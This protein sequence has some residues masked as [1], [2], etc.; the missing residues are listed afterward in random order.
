[1]VRKFFKHA[2]LALA[3]AGLA[4]GGCRNPVT[5]AGLT[6]ESYPGNQVKVNSRVFGKHFRVVNIAAAKGQNQL[7]RATISLENLQK[8]SM[9]FEYRFRWIDAE[10]IEINTG[11]TLWIS[12][13]AAARETVLLTGIAPTKL[14]ADFILDAR[15]V[16]PSTR[17]K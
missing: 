1:M 6:L 4:C 3:L 13:I 11:T 2:A 9:A 16:Y 5:S 12:K 14:A 7:L 15:F 10:G 17:W 8:F